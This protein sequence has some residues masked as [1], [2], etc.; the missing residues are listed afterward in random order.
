MQVLRAGVEL[1]LDGI[2]TLHLPYVPQSGRP[3]PAFVGEGSGAPM[4]QL[5]TSD[6]V[7][8]PTKKILVQTSLTNEIQAASEQTAV[9][10]FSEALSY[11][12]ATAMD[13]A[14]F[15]TGAA[16][17]AAPAGLLNGV[18]PLS[19]SSVG[20]VISMASDLGNIAQA[21]ANAGIAVHDLIFVTN[22]G[23]EVALSVLASPKFTSTVL[24]SAAIPVGTVIGIAPAGLY[25]G[26]TGEI[27]IEATREVAVVM[28]SAPGAIM[29]TTT[30]SAFQQD[31]IV[32]RLR[33]RCAW[34]AYPGAVQCINGVVW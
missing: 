25:V 6:Q 19:P 33:A 11:A 34:T 15:G 24:S 7:L 12:T 9:T 4:V 18:A 20:G 8:G 23:S 10:M 5:Q 29:S 14:L 32:V 3:V 30:F 13:A 1:R 17:A 27:E 26:Y 16:S 21:I 28:D 31:L 22:P 2:N